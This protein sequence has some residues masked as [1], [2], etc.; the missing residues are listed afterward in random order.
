MFFVQHHGFFISKRT[1]LK[2][3]FLG[4]KGGCN[5]TVFFINLCF[6]KCQ[7]LSFFCVPF[8]GKFWLMFE[9]HYKIGISAHFEKPKIAKNGHF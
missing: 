6:A 7:K 2:K 8:W 3:K 5:K 4:Q 9:K 1:T